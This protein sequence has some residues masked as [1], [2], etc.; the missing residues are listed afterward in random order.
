MFGGSAFTAL[1]A[2]TD[3]QLPF[4]PLAGEMP[5][6]Y[7]GA[8]SGRGGVLSATSIWCSPPPPLSL[9]DI[10]PRKG[11]RAEFEVPH[12]SLAGGVA[13]GRGALL[14]T[15]G[16]AQRQSVVP[17]PLWTDPSWLPQGAPPLQPS[18]ASPARG[19]A[20]NGGRLVRVEVLER[21]FGFV[22]EFLGQEVAAGEPD[23]RDIGRPAM[24][25]RHEPAASI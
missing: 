19:E 3:A 11:G 18:A 24:P 7:A 10:S 12:R 9:R 21:S 20:R 1:L 5:P 23:A 25:G 2:E 4:S 16:L 14:S 22:R 8:G 6:A 15:G 17:R 13:E